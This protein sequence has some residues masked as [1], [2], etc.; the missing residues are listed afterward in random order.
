MNASMV[1]MSAGVVA[2][3]LVVGFATIMG[4]LDD[5]PQRCTVLNSETGSGTV[6][7]IH[8]E[9]QPKAT[10]NATPF[11]YGGTIKPILRVDPNPSLR[12][13]P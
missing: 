9:G 3:F 11:D 5:D 6:V 10:V 12:G 7:F 2:G 13:N 4:W 8:D 1:A